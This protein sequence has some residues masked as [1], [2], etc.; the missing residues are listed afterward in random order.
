M[1]PTERI[2]DYLQRLCNDMGVEEKNVYNPKTGAWYFVQGNSTIEVFLTTQKNLQQ[3]PQVFIRCI[4]VLCEI[5]RDIMKQYD[6]YK[7]SLAINSTYLGFKISADETR[8][9]ICIIS[10]RNISGMDY[11]EMLTLLHDLSLWAD[12]L[13]KF[14][15][16]Q[17]K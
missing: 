14:M 2:T 6:V 9:L 10:E 1:T 11:S 4:A 17:F 5:P 15:R 7:T 3:L 16:D 13:S 12:K 8:G